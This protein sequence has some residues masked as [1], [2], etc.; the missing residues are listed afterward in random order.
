MIDKIIFIIIIAAGLLL[1]FNLWNNNVGENIPEP[2]AFCPESFNWQHNGKKGAYII[3]LIQGE[4][5]EKLQ[6]EVLT[7]ETCEKD[8]EC[9][10]RCNQKVLLET[11]EEIEF[12]MTHNIMTHTCLTLGDT[13]VFS[14]CTK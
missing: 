14:Q 8:K 9:L 1:G 11:G 7:D 2:E 3:K 10:S 13:Y 5:E 6:G 4:I 12:I